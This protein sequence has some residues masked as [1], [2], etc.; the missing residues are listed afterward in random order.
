MISLYIR[1]TINAIVKQKAELPLYL[2]SEKILAKPIKM[3]L[4]SW[5]IR[6]GP[7]MMVLVRWLKPNRYIVTR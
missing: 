7:P 5:R 1:Y 2:V 6:T 4:E 3:S